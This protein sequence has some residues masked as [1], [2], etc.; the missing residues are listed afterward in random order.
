MKNEEKRKKSITQSEKCLNMDMEQLVNRL[1]DERLKHVEAR[2]RMVEPVGAVT[3]VREAAIQAD[4]IVVA[5]LKKTW[6]PILRNVAVPKHLDEII[7]SV[8]DPAVKV[9]LEEQAADVGYGKEVRE[10]FCSFRQ[11]QNHMVHPPIADCSRESL[12]QQVE[13]L[14]GY[15]LGDSNQPVNPDGE[16]CVQTYLRLRETLHLK[17]RR[18]PQSGH[19]KSSRRK[20]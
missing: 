18:Q 5:F 6:G 8:D 16:L 2:L 4:R 17:K 1:V 20:K 13:L 3:Y 9:Q 14:Y 12:E 11:D 7:E 15:T 10:K 19:K